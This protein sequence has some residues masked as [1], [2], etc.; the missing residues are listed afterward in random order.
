LDELDHLRSA[1]SECY[2]IEREIGRG[3]M[4]TVYLAQDLKHNRHVA[5]KVLRPDVT[6]IVGSE[7]FLREIQIEAS[8][9]HINILPIHDSGKSDGFLYYV[10][11]Y[12]EGESLRQRMDREVQLPLEE[13]LHIA[14]EIADALSYAHERGIVHRDIKPENILLSDGHAVLA[15]F[16]IAR[17]IG[18][19]GGKRIT[20]AGHAVG[21]PMYMSP[22][23]YTRCSPA[24]H[25][26]P[27][28]RHRRSSP[29]RF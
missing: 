16:G 13:A 14:H 22:A 2:L 6:S 1:L 17:A 27:A 25:R 21:T 15:D 23:C 18:A 4:A 20:S 19:A 24:S 29:V 3:G 10:M 11:P 7:R 9:Q 12:V 26:S 8:L 28:E 5:I